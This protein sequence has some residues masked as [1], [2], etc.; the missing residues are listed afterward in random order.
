MTSYI[1]LNDA[2]LDQIFGG[3]VGDDDPSEGDFDGQTVVVTGK[4][5]TGDTDAEG[6]GGK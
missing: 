4:R 1:E 3:Y 5:C 6:C 2:E